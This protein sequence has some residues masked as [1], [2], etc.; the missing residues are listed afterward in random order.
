MHGDGQRPRGH[1]EPTLGVQSPGVGT[2]HWGWT[3]TA[4]AGG[5]NLVAAE[6]SNTALFVART[7]P[8]PRGIFG[9][10]QGT[11]CNREHLL[12]TALSVRHSHSRHHL[13]ELGTSPCPHLAQPRAHSHKSLGVEPPRGV[14]GCAVT[15]PHRT[16]G[17]PPD[18]SACYRFSHN[19]LA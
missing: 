5:S 7:Y 11:D 4:L 3:G 12:G 18:C 6:M 14:S 13:H 15:S 17:V 19:A 1:A 10:I 16:L 9:Y 8:T 2:W